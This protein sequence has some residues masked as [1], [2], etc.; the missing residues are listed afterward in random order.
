MYAAAVDYVGVSNM[1]TFTNTIPPYWNPYLEMF[2][3]MVGNPKKDSVLLA[4]VSPALHAD[5]IKTPLYVAEGTNEPRVN[6]AE[7]D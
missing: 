7:S 2:H 1:F 6:K 3:E 5:K 4:Q